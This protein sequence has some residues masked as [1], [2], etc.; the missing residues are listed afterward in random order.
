MFSILNRLTR[1]YF[2]IRAGTAAPGGAYALR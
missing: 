1:K 2:V